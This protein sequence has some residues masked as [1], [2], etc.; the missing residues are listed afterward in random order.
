MEGDAAALHAIALLL[1][2]RAL[3][4]DDPAA[5]APPSRLIVHATGRWFQRDGAPVSCARFPLLQRL[6]VVLARARRDRP[7]VPLPTAELLAAGWP[8]EC[9]V[10]RAARNRLNV[11]LH[12]LRRL[13]LDGVLRR[14][15]GGWLI[16]RDVALELRDDA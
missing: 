5:A 8:A 4:R 3:T 9:I 2:L 11:A 15:P 10:P 6:L 14:A 13:G 7:G 12:R 1:L 16:A